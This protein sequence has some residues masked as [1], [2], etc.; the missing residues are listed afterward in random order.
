MATEFEDSAA[1]LIEGGKESIILPLKR[2]LLNREPLHPTLAC[3]VAFGEDVA[4]EGGIIQFADDLH[5]GVGREVY[6]I[7]RYSDVLWKEGS[8][9]SAIASV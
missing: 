5:R 3:F 4:G 2:Q 6:Q 1:G 7:I 8:S 9:S